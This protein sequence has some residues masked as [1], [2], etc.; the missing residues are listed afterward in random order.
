[1]NTLVSRYRS[2]LFGRDGVGL[3]LPGWLGVLVGYVDMLAGL[4]GKKLPISSIRVKKFMGTTAFSTTISET[5][6]SP[7]CSVTEGIERTLRHEFLEDHSGDEL[8]YSE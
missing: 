2:V 8:F 3:R 7:S 1:M 6:F 4:S 5:A